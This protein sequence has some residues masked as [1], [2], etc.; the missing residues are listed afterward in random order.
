V[1]TYLRGRGITDLHG[2]SSLRFHPR[3]C[4]RPEADAP[5]ETWPAMRLL[6]TCRA[7]SPARTV[8][9][10]IRPDATRRWSIPHAGR[11]VT[12][13]GTRSASVRQAT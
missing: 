6:P 1:E 7:A 12:F 2:I 10:S 13:S 9:G 5:T 11:W 4:Y 8:H 3:C